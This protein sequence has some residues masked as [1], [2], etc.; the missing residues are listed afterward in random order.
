MVSIKDVAQVAEVSISTVSRVLN[1]PEKTSSKARQRVLEVVKRLNYRPN[2]S[3]QGFRRSTTGIIG[4]ILPAIS[5]PYFSAILAGI[6]TEAERHLQ[7]VIV[8]PEYSNDEEE[9]LAL[10]NLVNK[11]VDA[12]IYLPRHV[13]VPPR[14]LDY[15]KETP[16]VGVGRRY[17]GFSAPCV[18]HDAVKSGYIS[19]KYLISLGCKRIAFV[20]GLYHT[21]YVSTP[22]QL[23][24]MA[25]SPLAGTHVA[26]DRFSGYKQALDEADIPYDPSLVIISGFTL[27]NGR[28][29][30]Q[31]L[32]ILGNVDG[33]IAANDL[34][35]HTMLLCLQEQGYKV[36][37]DISIIGFDDIY[38]ARASNPPITTVRQDF[39]KMGQQALLMANRLLDKEV[40]CE[41][42]MLDVELIVRKSTRRHDQ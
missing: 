19:A 30:A 31:Q 23:E 6:V 2:P 13:G 22:A 1:E 36:P 35:A 33:I 10:A 27:A 20:A 38:I 21:G 9:T 28:S 41:D 11:P 14:H 15:F 37:E 12:L 4:T 40:V 18:Y 25:A 17:L 16:I 8:S 39:R 7:S 29:A 42:I 3:A 24:E 32:I 34:T 5:M 26:A